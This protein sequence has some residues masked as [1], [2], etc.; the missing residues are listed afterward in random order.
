MSMC[1][2]SRLVG[3]VLAGT[4]L[5]LSACSLDMNH[6]TYLSQNKVQ[7]EQSRYDAE[8]SV[9]ALDD[10]FYRALA[11]EY[12]STGGGQLYLTFVYNPESGGSSALAASELAGKAA[13]ALRGYGVRDVK[14]D[15]LPVADSAHSGKVLISYTKYAAHAPKDCKSMPGLDDRAVELG[16]DYKYGCSIDSQIA[17][18]IARPKDLL[19]NDVV[20]E[21][22][23]GRRAAVTSDAHEG[24][25]P[26]EP[27]NIGGITDESK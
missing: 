6:P 17:D 11:Q 26:N 1:S 22:S 2:K 3:V 14:A 5:G 12:K 24:G 9:H 10:A 18:Q 27:L 13:H 25:I 21:T 7:V 19:G 20:P 23:S 15:I 8:V 4:A 16:W